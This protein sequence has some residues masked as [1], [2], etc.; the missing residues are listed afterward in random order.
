M[1]FYLPEY[2]DELVD[3]MSDPLIELLAREGSNEDAYQTAMFYRS[4]QSQIVTRAMIEQKHVLEQEVEQEIDSRSVTKGVY[5]APKVV[6]KKYR[7]FF[8]N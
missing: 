8:A 6:T 7:K 4:G 5:S 1:S 3:T 2:I